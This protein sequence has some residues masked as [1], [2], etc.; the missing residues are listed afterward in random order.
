M[1]LLQGQTGGPI[2]S[3]V[4]EESSEPERMKDIQYLARISLQVETVPGCT[5]KRMQ[6]NIKK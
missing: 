2:A 4:P 5:G 6:T 1:V 3:K